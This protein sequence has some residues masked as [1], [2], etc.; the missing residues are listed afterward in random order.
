MVST[1]SLPSPHRSPRRIYPS[2]HYRLHLPRSKRQLRAALAESS[3]PS[4]PCALGRAI[5]QSGSEAHAPRVGAE[6]TPGVGADGLTEEEQ[7][8]MALSLSEQVAAEEAA[9]QPHPAAE[10][11]AEGGPSAAA[12]RAADVPHAVQASAVAQP[13]ALVSGAPGDGALDEDTQLAMALALS[14]QSA[15]E[16]AQSIDAQQQAQLQAL[17]QAQRAQMEARAAGMG[18]E[19]CDS[20]DARVA[21]DGDGPVGVQV[22]VRRVC[23]DGACRPLLSS[24]SALS[25]GAR[26]CSRSAR[27]RRTTPCG[28]PLYL[29]CRLASQVRV[30]GAEEVTAG[31]SSYTAYRLHVAS[32]E[33]SV[34]TVSLQRFSVSKMRPSLDSV[35]ALSS[36]DPFCAM[37]MHRRLLICC[38][39]L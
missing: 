22:R 3:R 38:P 4:S 34:P 31:R 17:E 13:N 20:A 26:D 27:L 11:R 7:L 32:G 24:L 25:R 2:P 14:M 35:R 9:W 21:M 5:A 37:L 39:R 16:P 19:A 29:A 18:G 10:S 36:H 8:A 30:M 33:G 28:P 12:V 1:P 6:A 15:D 23:R